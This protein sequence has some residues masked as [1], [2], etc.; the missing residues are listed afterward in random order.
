MAC[1]E[2]VSQQQDGLLLLLIAWE[3]VNKIEWM[4]IHGLFV[5]DPLQNVLGDIS[6]RRNPNAGKPAKSSHKLS[7]CGETAGSTFIEEDE[8]ILETIESLRALGFSDEDVKWAVEEARSKLQEQQVVSSST[9]DRASSADKNVPGIED[10]I[11]RLSLSSHAGQDGTSYSTRTAGSDEPDG[12]LDRVLPLVLPLLNT[13]NI[14]FLTFNVNRRW[15]KI[16]DACLKVFGPRG[17]EEGDDVDAALSQL[18]KI[19]P[20]CFS[21]KFPWARFL[22]QGG[23]KQVF[24]VY[25]EEEERKEAVRKSQDEGVTSI[26]FAIRFVLHSFSPTLLARA[27]RSTLSGERRRRRRRRRRRPDHSAARSSSSGQAALLLLNGDVRTTH[28]RRRGQSLY[29]VEAGK[30]SAMEIFSTSGGR[31]GASKKRGGVFGG[32]GKGGKK[33]WGEQGVGKESEGRV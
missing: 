30:R 19:D 4:Y 22:A 31:G 18:K 16:S 3:F 2:K 33:G 14:A 28:S 23:F 7:A 29:V 17:G 10:V 11:S 12:M 13:W 25:N 24:L 6:N 21:S 20:A 5:D 15:R 26:L 1:R 32:T 8:T 27:S 9:K